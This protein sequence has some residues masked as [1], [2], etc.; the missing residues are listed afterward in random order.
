VLKN[1]PKPR[2]KAGPSRKKQE[3]TKKRL[4]HSGEKKKWQEGLPRIVPGL[5]KRTTSGGKHTGFSASTGST[6]LIPCE[7]EAGLERKGKI[8]TR[9]RLAPSSARGLWEVSAEGA[10][11]ATADAEECS[12]KGKA[13]VDANHKG[14]RALGRRQQGTREEKQLGRRNDGQ[15]KESESRKG[16]F[17]SSCIVG[18]QVFSV[19][20]MAEKKR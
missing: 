3:G 16:H 12:I 11:Q 6:G 20:N 8:D 1:W 13:F 7:Q 4:T 2:R 19:R 14:K 17:A 18:D 10:E 15:A 5:E 9:A